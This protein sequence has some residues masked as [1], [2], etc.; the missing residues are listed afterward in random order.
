[1][2]CVGNSSGVPSSGS[3]VYGVP[4]YYRCQGFVSTGIGCHPLIILSA[5]LRPVRTG[6]EASGDTPHPGRGET[7]APR[8]MSGCQTWVYE[9]DSRCVACSPCHKGD[10]RPT[11]PSRPV[12]ADGRRGLQQPG[13]ILSGQYLD[14]GFRRVNTNVKRGNDL[15]VTAANRRGYRANAICQVFIGE[16]PAP[17]SYLPQN[18]VALLSIR[19]PEWCNAGATWL[20]EHS[21]Q[22]IWRQLREQHFSERGLKGRKARADGDRQGDDFGYGDT[23]DVDD[24]G[25][26]ELCEGGR[27]A[28]KAHQPLHVWAGYLPDAG[29][30]DISHTQFQHA[31]S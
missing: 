7:P 10:L 4:L 23:R 31:W 15:I 12:V 2:Q 14:A 24:I 21:F 9:S 25:P 13:K 26:I 3:P 19:L 11:L 20:C 8:V 28:R 17:H 27:F 6:G 16:R 22:F 29:R 5:G 18:A 30:A 1:M